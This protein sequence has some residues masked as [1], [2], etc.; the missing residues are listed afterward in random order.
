M[1]PL[2]ESTII[3][4]G[5]VRN[6]ENGLKRNIPVIDALCDQAKEYK[7]VVYE[8]DSKDNTKQILRK[9][10]VDRGENNVHI[11]LNDNVIS[12]KTIPSHKSTLCNPFFSRQRI[13]KMVFLR[14]QYLTYISEK[15][16][17]ADYMI[18]VDLDVGQLF[19]NGILSSFALDFEWDAVTAY[20]YSFSPLL[21]RRFHDTYPLVELGE[22]NPQTEEKIKT[23]L[24]KYGKL[25]YMDKPIRVYS[26]FGGLAIYRYDAFKG[27][28]Y[29][30]MPN[31][32]SKVEMCC[33]HYSIF[34]QMHQKG[35]TNVFVNP[36]MYLRY[37]N[38]TFR[39][40]LNSIKLRFNLFFNKK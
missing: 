5:I 20:G 30:L 37:E 17:K 16:W 38:I 35:Y 21:K 22:D 19:L 32:D 10:A 2:N 26:A 1:K 28:N 31:N 36:K 23:N 9:W 27:I 40:I 24:Y 11:L 33:E 39:Y 25:K 6:A 8:N 4:C 12:G 13:E 7:I 14:N 15:D 18:V 34:Y 3:I 29:C